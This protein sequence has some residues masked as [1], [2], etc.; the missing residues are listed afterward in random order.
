[1]IR[2]LMVFVLVGWVATA[3]P[4]LSEVEGLAGASGPQGGDRL[5]TKLAGRPLG[6]VLRELQATGLNI[7][8]S[9]ET[10]GRTM[11]V[12]AEPKAVQP[13]TILD[14]IL[15]PHG[16]QVRPGP[17]GALL[18]VRLREQTSRPV[19]SAGQA[20]TPSPVTVAGQVVSGAN[21]APVAGAAV[22]TIG[23]GARP[24]SPG[25][26]GGTRRTVTDAAGRF[27]IDATPG[28]LR[29]EVTAK[30][31]TVLNAAGIVMNSE[32]PTHNQMELVG[33]PVRGFTFFHSRE[34]GRALSRLNA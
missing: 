23:A 9:S 30:N 1:M 25:G 29:L 32:A 31:A 14:E 26:F 33:V 8:F 22:E 27:T 21:K 12:L 20:Q 24:P 16:L 13:R 4:A 34:P 19:T 28:T 10:V 2:H 17:G 5:Q 18:V 6:D 3:L 7:V 15:R 11:R